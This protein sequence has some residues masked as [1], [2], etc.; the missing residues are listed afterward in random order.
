[1]AQGSKIFKKSLNEVHNASVKALKDCGFTINE[2]KGN[3]IKASSDISLA[4]W[5]EDIEVSLSAK[6]NGIEVKATSEASQIFDW[7]KNE[8][9]I[10]NIFDRIERYLNRK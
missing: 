5:G 10:S 1:M 3:V 6:T 8:E 4:S 2:K 7:G 9:N